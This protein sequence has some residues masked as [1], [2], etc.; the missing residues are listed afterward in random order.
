MSFD[1]SFPKIGRNRVPVEAEN[2]TI[3]N[4]ITF[5]ESTHIKRK[6]TPET[7]E[8]F[9]KETDFEIDLND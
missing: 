2:A 5:N 1:L 6:P 4:L 8:S 3:P 9:E 7:V